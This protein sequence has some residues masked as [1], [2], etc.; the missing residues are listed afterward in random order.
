MTTIFDELIYRDGSANAYS[1]TPDGDGVRFEYD[2]ITP[3]R[4]STGMYSGG[5]PRAGRLDAEQLALL[6]GQVRAL[7]ENTALHVTDRGKGTGLFLI[8]S[9]G[10]ERSFIIV[11]GAELLAFDAFVGALR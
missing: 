9:A 7:E 4:S 11:R 1:F 10:G 8:K 5:D 6:W 2:P 3:E